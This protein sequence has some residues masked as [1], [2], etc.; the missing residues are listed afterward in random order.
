MITNLRNARELYLTSH[1]LQRSMYTCR[2]NS[3]YCLQLSDLSIDR[4]ILQ[5]DANKSSI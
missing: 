4:N 5:V 2:V 1:A 3:I